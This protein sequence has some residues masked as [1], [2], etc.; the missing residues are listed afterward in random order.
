MNAEEKF[1]KH[2]VVGNTDECWEHDLAGD[3]DGY[4]RIAV[5]GKTVGLHRWAYAHFN[6]VVIAHGMMVCHSCDNT[7]CCNPAHLFLGT[8]K[9]NA[10]DRGAKG[11][12]AAAERNGRAKLTATQGIPAA[13]AFCTISKLERPPMKRAR[14]V[15]RL[16]AW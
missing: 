2:V 1:Y 8:A 7:R 5:A 10:A 11:R 16:E 4:G 15:S 13:S 6:D 9:V 14:R 3:P 12:T